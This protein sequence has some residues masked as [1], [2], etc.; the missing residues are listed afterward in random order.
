MLTSVGGTECQC[1]DAKINGEKKGKFCVSFPSD[2][3][4]KC[5]NLSNIM[6]GNL[7]SIA[8]CANVA[9]DASYS[10]PGAVENEEVCVS[11]AWLVDNGLEEH[12]IH[13]GGVAS[14]LCIPG[15]P[16]ATFGHLL[17]YC[18]P[19]GGCKL[20]TYDEVCKRRLDCTQTKTAVS[21]LSHTFDWSIYTSSDKFLQL[22]SLSVHPRAGK[23]ALSRLIAHVG[24]RLNS[25]GYGQLT[26]AIS[27][28]ARSESDGFQFMWESVR[29]PEGGWDKIL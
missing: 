1:A 6:S 18:E 10:C 2:A 19:F 22:T 8:H 24:D 23:M 29:V 13:F 7:S 26:N 15:L 12:T 3:L 11:T 27:R 5:T 14:V 25:N 28:F 17:R 16:C 4:S 20:V 9:R 21:Q